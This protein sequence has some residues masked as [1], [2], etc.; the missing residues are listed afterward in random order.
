[1]VET[2]AKRLWKTEK[3]F[4]VG[5]FVLCSKF[6]LVMRPAIG[7]SA[8]IYFLNRPYELRLYKVQC[9]TRLIISLYSLLYQIAR[10]KVTELK[11]VG[12]K[13]SNLYCLHWDIKVKKKKNDRDVTRTRNLLIWNQT[14]YH[15]AT[16]PLTV[17]RFSNDF[18]PHFFDRHGRLW[19][20][21]TLCFFTGVFLKPWA[22]IL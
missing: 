17:I 15:C 20:E 9:I 13:G 6:I 11:S 22:H 21:W 5:S 16:Q 12:I 2:Y 1:M 18:K 4:F 10:S 7:R 3:K 14:R 19:F 8:K